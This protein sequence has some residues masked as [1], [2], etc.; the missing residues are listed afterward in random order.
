MCSELREILL[1]YFYLLIL[2]ATLTLAASTLRNSCGPSNGTWLNQLPYWREKGNK[3]N[4]AFDKN[5][6]TQCLFAKNV[7]VIGIST[8]R[9]YSFSLQQLL[10]GE[11]VT[12]AEQ[13]KLCPKNSTEGHGLSSCKREI[14]G[15]NIKYLFFHYLDGFNYTSRG[16]FP[17]LKLKPFNKI[18]PNDANEAIRM[19][20]KEKEI[21]GSDWCNIYN[22]NVRQCLENFFNGSQSSG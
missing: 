9:Q 21:Y 17:F 14:G 13:K 4:N 19:Y 3:A 18:L 15:T 8:A 6:A 22:G 7:Y 11:S 10:G 1:F 5:A 16:G 20:S 12:R 2:S